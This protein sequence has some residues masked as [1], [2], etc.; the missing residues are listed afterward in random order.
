MFGHG[1]E[2]RGLAWAVE[3][4][5]TAANLEVGTV[6]ALVGYILFE[7]SSKTILAMPVWGSEAPRRDAVIDFLQGGGWSWLDCRVSSRG[8]QF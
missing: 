6:A 5:F 7:F 3:D 1:A 2:E 8:I 4:V